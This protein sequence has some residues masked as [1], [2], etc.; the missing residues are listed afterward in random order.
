[1]GMLERLMSGYCFTRPR[2]AG[3]ESDGDGMAGINSESDLGEESQTPL[4]DN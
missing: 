1:M 3:T 2:S 4:D